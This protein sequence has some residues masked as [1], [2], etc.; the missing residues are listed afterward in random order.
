M[1]RYRGAP[2]CRDLYRMVARRVSR[3]LK[4]EARACLEACLSAPEG[5]TAAGS[6][7]ALQPPVPPM[8][9]ASGEPKGCPLSSQDAHA[10]VIPPFGFRL[11]QASL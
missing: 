4:P 10:G 11:R 2:T 6:F 7:S 9:E 5:G 8:D 3:L 1:L